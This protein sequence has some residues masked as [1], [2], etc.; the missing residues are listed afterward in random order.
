MYVLTRHGRNF[1]VCLHITCI[2]L[3]QSAAQIVR[4]ADIIMFWSPNAFEDVDVF[5]GEVLL[6]KEVRNGL[7][8]LRSLRCRPAEPLLVITQVWHARE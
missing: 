1:E 3:L 6:R 7:R 4:H 2:V 5:H 8:S